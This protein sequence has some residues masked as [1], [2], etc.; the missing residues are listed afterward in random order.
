MGNLLHSGG[1]RSHGYKYKGGNNLDAVAWHYE[2]SGGQLHPVGMKKPNELGIY[3]MNGNADEWVQ[4]WYGKYDSSPQIDPKGPS[5]GET[6][7]V[8]GW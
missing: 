3:D 8:R 1:K 6:R 7:V 4:D 5:I 2:N